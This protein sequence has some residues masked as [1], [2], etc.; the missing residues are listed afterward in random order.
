MDSR[1]DAARPWIEAARPDYPV[2]IDRTREDKT[3]DPLAPLLELLAQ[4]ESLILFPEG[5]RGREAVPAPFKSGLYRLAQAQPRVELIPVYLENLHRSM[6][7]GAFFP[8]PLTCTVRFGAPLAVVPN[9]GK[10]AFLAR[11]REEVIKLSG[12]VTVTAEAG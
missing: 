2:L 7:R 8:I 3:T 1:A 11:A 9:E 6:P 12:A 5:T 4:G 10:D